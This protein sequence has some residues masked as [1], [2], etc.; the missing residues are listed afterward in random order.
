MKVT[1][2]P[3]WQGMIRSYLERKESV[4]ENTILERAILELL[5]ATGIFA[6][7]RVAEFL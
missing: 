4:T 1:T 7:K 5:V 6:Q 2:F 3:C